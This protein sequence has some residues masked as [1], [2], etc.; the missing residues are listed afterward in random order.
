[1]GTG[2]VV[3]ADG[4]AI[5]LEAVAHAGAARVAPAA[6]TGD[7]EADARALRA[8]AGGGAQMAFD[9]VGQARDPNATLAALRSPAPRRKACFNGEHEFAAAAP[10]YGV[11]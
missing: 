10:L 3:A 6:L 1:M 5:A 11:M 7:V 8:T 4:N 9:M 2:R